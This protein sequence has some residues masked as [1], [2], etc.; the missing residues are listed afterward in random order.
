V[1]RAVLKTA[2]AKYGRN[3]IIWH[4]TYIINISA[5]VRAREI[6]ISDREYVEKLAQDQR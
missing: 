1:R 6:L 3:K 5:P 2:V 4:L